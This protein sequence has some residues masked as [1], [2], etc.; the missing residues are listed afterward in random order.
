MV[1]CML[2]NLAANGVLK[3]A[4]VMRGSFLKLRFIVLCVY[5]L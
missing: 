3:E 2:S 4:A 5:S 1:F